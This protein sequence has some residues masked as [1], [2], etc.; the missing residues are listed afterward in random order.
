MMLSKYR[1][2]HR[3]WR[4]GGAVRVKFKIIAL[5]IERSVQKIV[6]LMCLH[7]VVNMAGKSVYGRVGGV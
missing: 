7:L 1:T 4:M 5:E 2:K 6:I 3:P